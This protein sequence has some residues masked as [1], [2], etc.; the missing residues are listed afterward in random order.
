MELATTGGYADADGAPQMGLALLPGV[1]LAADLSV[2]IVEPVSFGSG[3]DNLGWHV[4]RIRERQRDIDRAC[5]EVKARAAAII[6]A[7]A[8]GAGA[9]DATEAAEGARPR[10]A[11]LRSARRVATPPRD[12]TARPRPRPSA[13]AARGSAGVAGRARATR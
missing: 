7:A 8:A 10:R 9:D 1:S 3:S 12:R 6:A 11:R 5:S 2:G 13:R 4:D